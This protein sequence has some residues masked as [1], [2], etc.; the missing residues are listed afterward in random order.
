MKDREK[1]RLNKSGTRTSLVVVGNEETGL[2]AKDKS[3]GS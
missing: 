2:R 3:K 1:K